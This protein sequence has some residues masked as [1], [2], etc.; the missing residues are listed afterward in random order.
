MLRKRSRRRGGSKLFGESARYISTAI[1]RSETSHSEIRLSRQGEETSFSLDV[2]SIPRTAWSSVLN[3]ITASKPHLHT[4][5]SAVTACNLSYAPSPHSPSLFRRSMISLELRLCL[6]RGIRDR[7]CSALAQANIQELLLELDNH[8]HPGQDQP[9][10]R[11]LPSSPTP[12]L[13]RNGR[14]SLRSP[15]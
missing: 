14:S 2:W 7:S 3:F 8:R 10:L 13:H 9:I 4:S 5:L 1:V 15:S 6:C 12:L 11:I